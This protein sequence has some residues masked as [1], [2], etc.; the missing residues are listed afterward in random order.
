MQLDRTLKS[1]GV[2]PTCFRI[3]LQPIML[4]DAPQFDRTLKI[5]GVHPTSF[6]IQLQ[7]SML[8]DAPQFDRT[9]KI[10]GV[11]PTCFRIHL[12][13][14]MLDDQGL[15]DCTPLFIHLVP[16]WGVN[17]FPEDWPSGQG[18][19]YTAKKYCDIRCSTL[20]L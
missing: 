12:Q 4:D 16:V 1:Y 9:L 18:W 7:P 5:Y 11:H 3:Q 20:P 2:H 14:S 6:R 13:P 17:H 15:V 8:D 19:A 10:Y